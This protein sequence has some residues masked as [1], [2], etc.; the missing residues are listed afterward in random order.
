[1]KDKDWLEI[2]V[3]FFFSVLVLVALFLNV[4]WLVAI[5]FIIAGIIGILAAIFKWDDV[6]FYNHFWIDLDTNIWYRILNGVIGLMFIVGGVL[7]LVL[8][9]KFW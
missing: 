9:I 1:M 2:I 8:K 6:L 5:C 3:Y 7:I 4:S